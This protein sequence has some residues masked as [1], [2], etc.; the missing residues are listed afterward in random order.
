MKNDKELIAELDSLRLRNRSLARELR[1]TRQKD[2][3]LMRLTDTFY[4]KFDEGIQI[5]PAS[6]GRPFDGISFVVVAYNIPRQL[7]RTL[8]SLSPGYQGIEGNRLEVIVID[9]GSETPLT[10]QDFGKFPFVK[11]VIRVEGHPSP[12]HGLNRGIEAAR[13]DTIALMIDGA[14]MLTPG[15]VR[16]TR[17]LVQ[18]APRPV[19][20]V[21]QY[22]LGPASQNLRS[23]GNS[24]EAEG[25]ALQELGWPAQG[26]SLFDY[27]VM[28]GEN[29]NRHALD[30][31]ESNC[32]ITT[33]EV[34]EECGGFDE[35]FDEPGAGLANIEFFTRLVHC[36]EN[37]YILLP[38]EGSFHQDHG[39]TTTSATTED[40]ERLVESFYVKYREVTGDD[41]NFTFRSPFLFGE[42]AAG[43]RAMPTISTE[44]GA[45]KAAI[46]REL[47]DIYIQRVRDDVGGPIPSLTLKKTSADERKIR[48]MLRPAGLSETLDASALGYRTILKR[49]HQAIRPEQYFEI[50]VDDG[51]SI[52]LAECP[53]IGV[54]PGY[55]LVHP[56]RFPTRIFRSESDAFFADEVLC[57]SLFA[58]RFQ[59]AF[60][61]GMHLSEYV[62][63]DFVNVERW[64][65]SGCTIVIDDVYPEQLVMAQRE[66]EF[67]AWCGDVY[68]LIFVLQDYRPDLDVLVFE[69]MAGPY[70]KGIAVIQGAD[71]DNRVLSEQ[72]GAIE[73]DLV[74]DK[75]RIASIAELGERLPLYPATEL[76][77]TYEELAKVRS[78]KIA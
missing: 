56:L 63:R 11:Q 3:Q 46:L 34:L 50:G 66:R 67:N 57:R 72:A 52:S 73:R 31:I 74:G 43:N 44:Y 58:D 64:L 62:F 77:R 13:F 26:Y 33:R 29:M 18:Y 40:R 10:M 25:A 12:V 53:S 45:A 60:I 76:A 32:L 17:M 20:N 4:R 47:A 48:P 69:A 51:G 1:I 21:P 38:G 27:G 36:P 70:R 14:H 65:G 6:G 24:F 7:Q 16:N 22:T 28:P 41:H 68:K 78:V 19:I 37:Q 23:H 49:L 2:R 39:G 5:P 30:S 75:Y 8:T 9:N 71:P 61:D 42:V 55:E 54:D 59:L 15:V 35:R